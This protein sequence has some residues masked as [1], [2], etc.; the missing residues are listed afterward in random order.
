MCMIRA[1]AKIGH[2]DVIS[3]VGGDLSN[4]KNVD[5]LYSQDVAMATREKTGRFDKFLKLFKGHDPYFI[6]PE[7]K[8]KSAII[9]DYVRQNHYDYI[10][11][12]Y[13][14]YALDCGLLKYADRLIID[15][16]DDPKDVILTSL[17]KVKTL[18]NKVYTLFYANMIDKMT[19]NI[20]RSVKAAFYSTPSKKYNNATYLPNISAYNKPLQA[21]DFNRIE[22]KIM[23]VGK[24]NYAPNIEGLTHFIT[25]VFPFVKAQIPNVT[26]NIVGNVTDDSLHQLCETTSGINMLGFVENIV[27]VYEDCHCAIIP[28]YQ[29]TGTCVKLIEA[30]ALG[31]AVVTTPC[32]IRGLNSEIKPGEAFLLAH[33]D[34]EFAENIVLLLKDDK[35]NENI[36][37]QALT[38]INRYY[39]VSQF[40][41][42]ITTRF[43]EFNN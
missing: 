26:L 29:G 2:V 34:K 37:K 32:G 1:L 6:Y 28:I 14:H 31:R 41:N 21:P 5:V 10:V 36:S 18:R 16:D 20:V 22:R 12:R 43:R 25:H 15:I 3:F 42:C 19:R 13:V 24:F 17:S 7:N 35:Y 33:N 8:E 40:E 27:S 23:I 30:M 9:D 11:T 39:S 4:E 38:Q